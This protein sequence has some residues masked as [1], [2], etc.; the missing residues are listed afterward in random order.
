MGWVGTLWEESKMPLQNIS[1][2]TLFI[3]NVLPAMFGLVNRLHTE[4]P[5]LT[6]AWNKQNSVF[7]GASGIETYHLLTKDPL[8][9]FADLK[10]Q[11]DY[12]RWN[13]RELALYLS[14]QAFLT[15]TICS[16]QGLLTAS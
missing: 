12:C 15:S 11:E 14:V 5:A 10:G 7:L 13:S 16:R 4:M 9:G 6:D 3:S 2:Y 8:D 1:F